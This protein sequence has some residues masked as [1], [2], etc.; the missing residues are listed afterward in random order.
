MEIDTQRVYR[1][2]AEVAEV[3]V[4]NVKGDDTLEGLGLGDVIGRAEFLLLLDRLNK[5]FGIELKPENFKSPEKLTVFEIVES[6]LES[7][8]SSGQS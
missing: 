4:E 7:I 5:E 1:I 8:R 3:P 6:I 2:V